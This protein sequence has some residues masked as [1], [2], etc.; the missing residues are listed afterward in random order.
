MSW[1]TNVTRLYRCAE[2][3]MHWLACSNLDGW[4]KFPAEAG[5]WESRLL[6]SM[7]EMKRIQVHE[8]PLRMG[9]NTGIPGAPDRARV[10][11][12]SPLTTAA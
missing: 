8:V 10:A 5:G 4:V 9:F 7:D 3:S 6:V 1:R 2:F 12:T 11:K